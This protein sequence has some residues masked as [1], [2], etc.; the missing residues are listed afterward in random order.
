LAKEDRQIWSVRTSAWKLI[1][2]TARNGCKQKFEL[3]DLQNDPGECHNAAAE[4]ADI[5]QS[6]L[7]GLEAYISRAVAHD[8]NRGN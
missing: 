6:L 1:K 8:V 7:H 4:R 2:Y 3:F 5:I